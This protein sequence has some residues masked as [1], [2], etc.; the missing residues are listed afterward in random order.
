MEE[1]RKTLKE[2]TEEPLYWSTDEIKN[3]NNFVF[4]EWV[5]KGRYD[6]LERRHFELQKEYQLAEKDFYDFKS[7][8]KT[9]LKHYH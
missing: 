4:N 5:S 7:A 1:I 2:A 3:W 6:E 9:I 8:V